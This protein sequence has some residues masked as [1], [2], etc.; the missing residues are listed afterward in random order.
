MLDIVG[1]TGINQIASLIQ[2]VRRPVEEILKYLRKP[3]LLGRGRSWHCLSGLNER[4]EFGPVDLQNRPD[5][6]RRRLEGMCLL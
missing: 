5:F 2:E 1:D 6:K 3:D 4:K